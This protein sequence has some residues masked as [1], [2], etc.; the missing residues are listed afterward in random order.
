M[1]KVETF[2]EHFSVAESGS[3]LL[4]QALTRELE[5]A[6]VRDVGLVRES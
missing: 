3:E 1:E 4:N 6:L 2:W 5:A